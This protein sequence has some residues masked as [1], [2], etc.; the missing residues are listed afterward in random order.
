MQRLTKIWILWLVFISVPGSGLLLSDGIP[1]TSRLELNP[2]S[3]KES[4]EYEKPTLMFN[5]ETYL[6]KYDNTKNIHFLTGDLFN[7]CNTLLRVLNLTELEQPKI[8]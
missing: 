4:L 8:N 1:F 7:D 6:D 2:I 5:L 3:I